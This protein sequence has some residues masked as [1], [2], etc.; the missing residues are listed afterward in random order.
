MLK[1]VVSLA[2][3]LSFIINF[4]FVPH[5]HTS[6]YTIYFVL[7]LLAISPFL[8]LWKVWLSFRAKRQLEICGVG[9]G[10]VGVSDAFGCESEE[11]QGVS[12]DLEKGLVEATEK[13]LDI[14]GP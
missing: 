12:A 7:S 13:P 1:E 2:I 6:S 9:R 3:I 4:V 8:L 14:D 10:L 11:D 5:P